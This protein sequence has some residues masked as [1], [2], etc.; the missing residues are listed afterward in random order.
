MSLNVVKTAAR[1]A[2]AFALGRR[3]LRLRCEDEREH[4]APP[5]QDSA[6]RR[7]DM[8]GELAGHQPSL[9]CAYMHATQL[10][11]FPSRQKLIV[12]VVF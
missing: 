11:D 8:R 2:S 10:G 9:Y 3:C 4:V 6:A 5:E 1:I 7:D 12:V